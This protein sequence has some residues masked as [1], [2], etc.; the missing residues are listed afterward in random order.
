MN[1]QD[2][3]IKIM[4][5]FVVTAAIVFS[6][7]AETVQNLQ[8]LTIRDAQYMDNNGYNPITAAQFLKTCTT[9]R[10]HY[11]VNGTNWCSAG[12][13]ERRY[14]KILLEKPELQKLSA[15]YKKST[16]SEYKTGFKY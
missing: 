16:C 13:L 2:V 10:K 3:I 5:A 6:A 8:G 11:C 14:L 12:F 4:M 9:L 7:K 1:Y 15:E